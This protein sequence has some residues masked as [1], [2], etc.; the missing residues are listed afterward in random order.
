MVE[1]GDVGLAIS[2]FSPQC[3]RTLVVGDDENRRLYCRFPSVV[4]C[5]VQNET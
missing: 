3:F 2:K 5:T 1:V 4:C